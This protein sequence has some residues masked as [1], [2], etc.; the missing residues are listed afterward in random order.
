MMRAAIYDRAA[1]EGIR[2]TDRI[3][4]V[5]SSLPANHVLLRV[6]AAGISPCDAKRVFG[7]KLPPLLAGV[8]DRFVDGHAAGFDFAGVVEAVSPD[9]TNFSVGDEVFGM[10]P[11]LGGSFAEA[12]VCPSDQ[13]CLKPETFS[14]VEAAAVPL[15]GLTAVQ[16]FEQ[17]H[18]CPGQQVLIIGA[19][20]GVGHLATQ[21]AVSMG[22][23]VAGVCSS[24]NSETAKKLG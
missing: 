17:H 12:V 14:M 1:P 24:K 10:V 16:L 11:I 15:I 7:D 21:V 23:T 2:V 6:A 19:T 3:R 4:P 8:A 13:L 18:L 22:A 5:A 20:G 9:V